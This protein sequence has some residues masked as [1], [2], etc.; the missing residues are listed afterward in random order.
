[1]AKQKLVDAVKGGRVLISDG[2][3]GTFLQKKGLKPGECPELWSAERPAE[4][5]EIARSYFA[6]GADMV[7]SNTF[8]AS[9][10]KLEHYNL[11]TRAAELNT[12]A[13]CLSAEAAVEAGGERWVIASVGPTGKM[14]L[15]G[16]VTE[17]ELYAAFKEQVIALEKGGADAICV[18]TMSALDEAT[19]AVKAAKENT[20]C[21]VIATF[22]FEKTVHNNYRTMMGVSPEQAAAEM[23][24]AGADIIGTNCGNGMERMVEIVKAMRSVAPEVPILVH[25]NAGLPKNVDGVDQFPETPE[26]MARQVSGLIAAGANIIGGCCGTTPAHIQALKGALR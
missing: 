2:A 24:A 20:G 22:T 8:G 10:F 13:A 16:D 26:D 4:V 14:L 17:E 23:I 3:W 6:A 19:L 11:E 7:Q 9:S 5:K 15:M 12:A 25:A 21:E 18:E 1:M